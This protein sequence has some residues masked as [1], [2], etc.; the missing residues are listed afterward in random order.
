MSPL[1]DR[2]ARAVA[3]VDEDESTEVRETTIYIDSSSIR[4]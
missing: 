3:E 2:R 4:T 1:P